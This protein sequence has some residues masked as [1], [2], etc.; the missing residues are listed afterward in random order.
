M[1]DFEEGKV[2]GI[3][4]IINTTGEEQARATLDLANEWDISGNVRSLIF[5]T[6]ASNLRYK[7][8][9][10]VRL[11]KLFSKKLFLLACRHRILSSVHKE[12]F[13]ATSGLT[14][15]NFIQFR[16]SIWPNINT[17]V[18]WTLRFKNRSLQILSKQSIRS[19]KRIL[20][21]KNRKN[22]LRRA[23]YRECAEL[24][25]ILLGERPE[26]KTHWVKPGA[27]HHARWMPSILYPVKMLAFSSKA[28]YEQNMI[29][30][31]EAICKFNALFY[32]ENWLCSSIGADVTY[33]D[34]NL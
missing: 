4:V 33:N 17:E 7:S 10:C 29:T 21:N 25:L 8:G 30:K 26:R 16:D 22:F 31:L 14:N 1:S 28:G 19:L 23:D 9:A 2:L 32:V 11:E 6:T 34:L 24:M 27:A 15:T 3:P 13:G 18:G 12:L 20:S 5:D